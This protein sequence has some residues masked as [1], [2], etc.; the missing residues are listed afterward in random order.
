MLIHE[1]IVE[2]YLGA[3]G[4]GEQYAEPISL[5]CYVEDEP[6]LIRDQTGAEVVSSTT[7]IY[8]LDEVTV[9]AL[10]VQSLVT[11][12]G[13]TSTVLTVGRGDTAGQYNAVEHLEVTLL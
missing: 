2:T 12:F 5:D 10:R 9:D 4:S 8:D 3:S 13:R 7:V 6:R 1:S 11:V